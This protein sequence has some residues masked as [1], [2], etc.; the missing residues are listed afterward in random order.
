M[1]IQDIPATEITIKRTLFRDTM[2]I[3][4]LAGPIKKPSIL[5]TDCH[6]TGT[7]NYPLHAPP[8]QR[9]GLVQTYHCYY[10]VL[11]NCLLFFR[12]DI[13]SRG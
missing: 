4:L 8:S 2:Y 12:Y 9:C 7:P 10:L 6:Q 3:F 11:F 13:Y 5:Q 1:I